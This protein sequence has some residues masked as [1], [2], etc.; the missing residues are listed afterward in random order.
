MSVGPRSGRAPL[1]IAVLASG[2][3][4]TLEAIATAIER[5]A[6]AARIVLVVVDRARAGAIERAERHHLR[7][8]RLSRDASGEA[9]AKELD[10]AL[11]AAGAELVVLAGFLALLPPSF[12][13]DWTGRVINLHPSLLPNFGGPGLYGDRVHA[14]VL[15]SGERESGA[16]VHLVTA[17][18]DRGPI[19][20]RARVPVEPGDT[21]ATLRAR[22]GPVEKEL[23]IAT[24]ARFAEGALPLPYRDGE[25]PADGRAARG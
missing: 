17:E 18:I 19:L 8:R 6:L 12:C 9:W 11:R 22:I 16:T 2:E 14:A 13:E 20:A 10:A 5:G 25:R 7:H 21:P 23:L 15:A 3:G 4:S 24:I 1:P